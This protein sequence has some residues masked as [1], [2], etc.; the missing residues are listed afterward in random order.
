MGGRRG[1]V[2]WWEKKLYEREGQLYGGRRNC[3][4]EERWRGREGRGKKQQG[5]NEEQNA[6]EREVEEKYHR[7][8]EEGVVARKE[9]RRMEW[10]G[11]NRRKDIFPQR[12]RNGG[13]SW[14]EDEWNEWNVMEEG[15]NTMG[16]GRMEETDYHGKWTGVKVMKKFKNG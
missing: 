16:K 7:E 3:V 13:M 10:C 5:D 14:S 9:G 4:K 12:E 1:T 11:R 6:M 15:L 8:R 2:I